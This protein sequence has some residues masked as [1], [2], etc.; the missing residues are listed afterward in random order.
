MADLL[1]F[2]KKHPKYICA[3]LCLAA[4]LLLFSLGQNSKT[5]ESTSENSLSAYKAELEAELSKM[6]SSIKGVGKCYVYVT[7]EKGAENSYKGG[8]LVESKPPKVLGVSIVC[9][10]GDSASVRRELTELF[11]SVFDIGSNRVKIS[12]LK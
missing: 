6:C 7:F 3:L 12:K 1:R 11:T 10:G 5:P 2:L 9:K 8:V 4:L